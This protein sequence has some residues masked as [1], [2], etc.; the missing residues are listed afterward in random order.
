MK[1][2][3]AYG[4]LISLEFTLPFALVYDT[5]NFAKGPSLG[6]E[7]TLLMPYVYLAH[8]DMIKS[9]QGAAFLKEHQ[10]PIDLL[11]V[12]VGC[13]DIQAIKK[14]FDKLEQIKE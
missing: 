4:G 10:L 1:N 8:Y 13:E 14:E 9:K 12:S 7:F 6:T 3:N 5:L 11:R 2:E